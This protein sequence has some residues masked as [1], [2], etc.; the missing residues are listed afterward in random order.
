MHKWLIDSVH[1][2]FD[3]LDC[4]SLTKV[5]TEQSEEQKLWRKHRTDSA[6]SEGFY[7]ISRKDKLKYLEISKKLDAELPSTSTQVVNRGHC[8]D[9]GAQFN[10]FS[11][12]C[13]HIYVC[14]QGTSLPAQQPSS[15][16]RAGS[17]FRS[18]QRRLLSSFSCDSDLLKFNQLKVKK[19][20]YYQRYYWSLL[21]YYRY[22][23]VALST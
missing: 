5:L 2:M 19:R 9:L 17:G 22:I 1:Y 7:K 20:Y 18:E 10:P 8:G 11:D 6:R 4:C 12:K 21:I 13:Q 14:L 16:L 3:I 15:L 23:C